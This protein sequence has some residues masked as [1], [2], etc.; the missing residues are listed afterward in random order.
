MATMST[1]PIHRFLQKGARPDR[2]RVQAAGLRGGWAPAA[3]AVLWVNIG[4]VNTPTC[5]CLF[6]FLSVYRVI[7]DCK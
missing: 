1:T 4:S 7:S 2:A 5:L 3:V 6:F